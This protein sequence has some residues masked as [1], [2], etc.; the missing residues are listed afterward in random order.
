MWKLLGVLL[1]FCGVAGILNRWVKEQKNRQMRLD[2]FLLFLQKSLHVMQKE[3]IRISDYFQRVIEQNTVCSDNR[4]EILQMSLEEI[5]KRLSLHTYPNG[6][7]VWEAVFRELE[8]VWDFDKEV[9][10]II[11]QAGNGFFGGSREENIS[12]LQKS[13]QE[14]EEQKTKLSEKNE[15]ERKVWIPVGMLGT[16]MFVIIFL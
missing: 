11:V 15:Q 3:K 8:G 9:F 2:A 16:M 12:F 4:N 14:L 10:Q 13:I 5:I 1:T 7:L 6:Q